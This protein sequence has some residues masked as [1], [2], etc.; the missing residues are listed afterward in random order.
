[1]ED[2]AMTILP[3]W[4]NLD[5]L[6]IVRLAALL[7]SLVLCV[8]LVQVRRKSRATLFLAGVFFGAFLFNAASFFEFAGAYY[9]HPRTLRTVFIDLFIDIGPSFAM[10]CLVLFAYHFPRF[11]NAERGEF[12][13]I[14]PLSLAVNAGVLGL[15][16]Y[17]NFVLLWQFSDVRLW[18]IYWLVFYCSLATQFLGATVLLFRK[19]MRLSHHGS[20]LF[21]VGILRPRG[22][23]AQA[24]RALGTILLL[25][26]L[27]VAASL[28]M[29]YGLLPFSV[30]T[31]LTWLGLLLFYLGFVVTY[32]N[33]SADP[34]TLQLK[35]LG[36]TLVLIL[37]TMGLVAL[38]V[39]E[40]STK[41]YRPPPL[42]ASHSTIRFTLNGLLS[43]DIRRVPESFDP[44]LGP[45][46]EMAYGRP[47]VAGLNFDFPFFAGRYRTIHVLNGPMIY[48]GEQVRENGWGGYN[49]QPAIAP[50]IMN[51]D[52][53]RGGGVYL[54][55]SPDSMTVTWFRIP[56]LEAENANTVQLVLRANGTIDMSFEALSP[57]HGPSIVQLY[58]Y[59]AASTTGSDPAPGGRPVPFPPRLTGIHPGGS[60]VPL[61]PISFTDDLPYSGARPAVIFESHEA[62]FAHYLN[63][64]IG[65][66]AALT[67]AACLLVLLLIP[68]MLRGNLFTPLRL[69]SR[70]M[71]QVEAGNL[72]A[73]IRVQSR[74]EIGSLARSFNRM[75]DGLKERF[76]LTKYVS[77]GTIE[78]VKT[79]QEPQRAFK[80]LLFT[81]VRGFTSYTE[82]RKPERVVEILNRLLECQSEII[83]RHGGD[84]DKFAGDEVFAVFSGDDGPRSACAAALGIAQLLARDAAEF[85]RLTV[86]AGIATGSVIQGMI[87]SVR[88]ADFTVIGDSVNLA[89]RLCGIAKGMQIV[90]SDTTMKNVER[91]FRFRGPFSVKV[92]GKS[93][94][95][96]VW[97]LTGKQ[98][99][100]AGSGGP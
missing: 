99:E 88:R 65:V 61:E 31:Y 89:S 87:G 60:H 69:L 17:N 70:G 93:E 41:D 47:F 32:L 75:V 52:P 90:V 77:G 42:P 37:S 27:A 15:N 39:G 2:A 29:T 25:P 98:R 81:D 20:R 54:K 18:N 19:A 5:S 34:L 95:Q 73:A 48:L 83:Q 21:L 74:D 24:A 7:L 58:N 97:I 26:M 84:I 56:E 44:D 94:S 85:E 10:V 82:R 72:D 13:I 9:W 76:E 79:S 96:R 92:K 55:S 50:I 86:G 3:G 45:E 38:F 59:A 14:F 46:V 57:S 62:G 51:L 68:L 64:R 1:L 80:T 23:D 53:S 91:D 22:Q 6:S 4:L 40:T 43:Y 100:A 63:A 11:R 35:L 30:A 28:A 8:Y 67:I 33:H 49:P 12:R 66:L 71:R 78:A 16:V 36:V